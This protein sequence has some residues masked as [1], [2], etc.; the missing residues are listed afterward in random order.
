[1]KSSDG[2]WLSGLGTHR[3][4]RQVSAACCTEFLVT[5]GPRPI[6][7]HTVMIRHQLLQLCWVGRTSL[8][9]SRSNLG[10]VRRSS[11][12]P[13]FNWC[14][15]Y[16]RHYIIYIVPLCQILGTEKGITLSTFTFFLV[17]SNSILYLS[18][19][20]LSRIYFMVGGSHIKLIN[21]AK[22]DEIGSGCSLPWYRRN[23]S[24]V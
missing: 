9:A 23:S 1:M 7:T 12:V 19:L 5:D 16:I 21:Y 10:Q 14:E 22:F 18:F 24:I 6:S 4:A 11:S 17:P 8:E 20:I 2:S 3:R 15:F 13:M